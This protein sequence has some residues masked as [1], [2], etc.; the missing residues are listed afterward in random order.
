MADFLQTW[1]EGYGTA[2]QQ[3]WLADRDYLLQVLALCIIH[4]PQGVYY[5][6]TVAAP[7]VRGIF[8]N[9]LPYL[10]ISSSG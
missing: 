10:G 6:G 5:G 1:A 7:V 3:S 4:D 2:E 8:E 9:V